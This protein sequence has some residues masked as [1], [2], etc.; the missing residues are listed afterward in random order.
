MLKV[1]RKRFSKYCLSNF[2]FVLR[3]LISYKITV[4]YTDVEGFLEK[5][6]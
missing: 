5:Y 2:L 4:K 3:F 6:S 1:F